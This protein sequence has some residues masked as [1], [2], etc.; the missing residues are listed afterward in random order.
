MIRNKTVLTL[1]A[2]LF[3]GGGCSAFAGSEDAAT[4]CRSQLDWSQ[5]NYE[6]ILSGCQEWVASGNY[7]ARAHY[8]LG[9]TLYQVGNRESAIAEFEKGEQAGD[10]LSGIARLFATDPFAAGESLA[11]SGVTKASLEVLARQSSVARLLLGYQVSFASGEPTDSEAALDQLATLYRSAAD[12]GQP[13]GAYL[14]GSVMLSDRSSDNDQEAVRF[15]YRAGE[16][17]VGAAWEAL[18]SLGELDE[19]PQ[20]VEE[21]QYRWA[22]PEDIVMRQD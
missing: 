1:G 13:V 9:R 17:G 22:T 3:L 18:V 2:I 8:Y 6:T 4:R 5:S 16:G 20:A 12:E 14:L 10:T 21:T 11:F 19:A 7:P 15:L